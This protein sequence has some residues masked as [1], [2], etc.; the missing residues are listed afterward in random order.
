MRAETNKNVCLPHCMTYQNAQILPM[1]MNVSYLILNKA[2]THF[3]NSIHPMSINCSHRFAA[4]NYARTFLLVCAHFIINQSQEINIVFTHPGKAQPF[5]TAFSVSWPYFPSPKAAFQHPIASWCSVRLGNALKCP[6]FGVNLPIKR[7]FWGI[8]Y[9]GNHSITI[10][11]RFT[12]LYR[13]LLE[14]L[15]IN[16]DLVW[17]LTTPDIVHPDPILIVIRLAW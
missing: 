8:C 4:S 2:D 17:I 10:N 11:R 15:E 9:T 6:V 12:W 14:K 3:I 13:W 5:W 1:C 16:T 7:I